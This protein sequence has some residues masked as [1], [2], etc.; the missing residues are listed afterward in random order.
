M[1]RGGREGI[2]QRQ[3]ACSTCQLEPLLTT[4]T[5]ESYQRYGASVG[6]RHSERLL[7]TRSCQGG[8]GEKRVRNGLAETQLIQYA[9]CV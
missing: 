8:G 9:L 2:P 3:G 4:Q 1:S 7:S 6:Q 5:F